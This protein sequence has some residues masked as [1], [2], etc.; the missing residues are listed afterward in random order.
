MSGTRARGESMAWANKMPA[1][2]MQM[3]TGAGFGRPPPR[4]PGSHWNESG[5]TRRPDDICMSG[6]VPGR[7]W[8]TGYRGATGRRPRSV[9]TRARPGRTRADLYLPNSY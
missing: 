3:E 1:V 6:D 2:L 5:P 9:P 7:G 8:E 4:Q